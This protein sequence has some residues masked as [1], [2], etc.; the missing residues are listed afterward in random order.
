MQAAPAG[1]A[2]YDFVEF[3]W[4]AQNPGSESDSYLLTKTP[5]D[6]STAISGL[7]AELSAAGKP[8]TPIMLGEVNS[9]SYN[10]GKQT[11]SIVNAL[12]TGMVIGEVLKNNLALTTWW[13]GAGERDFLQPGQVCCAGSRLYVARKLFDSVVAGIAEQANPSGS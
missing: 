8:N 1:Q 7:R 11:M 12:F 9:V 5:A 3:H 4:Y 13:F 10:P 6:L 2:P